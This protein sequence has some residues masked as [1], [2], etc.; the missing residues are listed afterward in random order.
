MKKFA[1]LL[2]GAVAVVGMA[3]GSA[4]MASA[5]TTGTTYSQ[6]LAGYAGANNGLTAYAAAEGTVTLPPEPTTAPA[7]LITG[8][9]VLQQQAGANSPTVG[10]GYIWNIGVLPVPAGYSSSA[11]ADGGSPADQWVLAWGQSPFAKPGVPLPP[12][13]L[14]ALQYGSTGTTPNVALYDCVTPGVPSFFEI[15]YSTRTDLI[16]LLAG[17]EPGVLALQ[18]HAPWLFGTMLHEFGFG[19]DTSN[20]TAASD[21]QANGVFSF[22]RDGLTTVSG[23][24]VGGHANTRIT[25]NAQRLTTYQGTT[26]GTSA[27][28]PSLLTGPMETGS[29]FTVT[30]VT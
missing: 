25:V 26:D 2:A 17:S 7:D 13:S 5:S 8:G 6:Y 22:T 30:S 20:G 24:V 14:T 27:G 9:V 18:F 15:Y 10:L 21:M 28:S 23:H 12:S 19:I 29:A 4:G 1:Y 3:L 16:N 11:C